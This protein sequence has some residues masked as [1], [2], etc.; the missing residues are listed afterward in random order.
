MTTTQLIEQRDAAWEKLALTTG[1][2][3]LAVGTALG[4]L[5]GWNLHENSDVHANYMAGLPSCEVSQN[6]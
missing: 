6:G 4:A 5:L 1:T 3:A 2:L